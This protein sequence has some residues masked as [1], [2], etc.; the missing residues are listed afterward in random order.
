L[1]VTSC[2]C[3]CVAPCT[4]TTMVY[5]HVENIQED[6][7]PFLN[8]GPE[9]SRTTLGARGVPNLSPSTTIPATSVSPFA[10]PCSASRCPHISWNGRIG[11]RCTVADAGSVFAP[12]LTAC[13]SAQV[14]SSAIAETDRTAPTPAAR[15]VENGKGSRAAVGEED[16]QATAAA[17]AAARFARYPVRALSG[18]PKSARSVFTATSGASTWVPGRAGE[19]PRRGAW[20]RARVYAR[21]RTAG[22]R[23]LRG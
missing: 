21:D 12:I 22:G 13:G 10:P 1:R 4:V 6:I 5:K 15:P 20:R 14:F 7:H 18:A 8:L 9:R 17:A 19:G 16:R 3:A 11:A 23:R 2:S